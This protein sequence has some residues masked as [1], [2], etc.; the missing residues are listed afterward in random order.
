MPERFAPPAIE[1]ADLRWR[2]A[3]AARPTLDMR[4]RRISV[5]P[6][7]LLLV[8]GL[9]GAGK[10]TLL[11]AIAGLLGTI[12]PGE[13]EGELTVGG[14][15]LVAAGRANVA[16]ANGG[17][18]PRAHLE[19]LGFIAAGPA[20]TWALP[21]VVDDAAL[22]LES[23]RWESST[24]RAHIARIAA[25]IGLRGDRLDRA[26]ATLSGGERAQ[27]AAVAALVAAPSLLIADEPLLGIDD[28]AAASLRAAIF[29]APATRVV[30]THDLERELTHL[31]HGA[32]SVRVCE[33][34]AATEERTGDEGR[35]VG[36]RTVE[37][38][39]PSRGAT[40]GSG[41][42][43]VALTGA[44]AAHRGAP[45]VSLS[46]RRG[47]AV[48][49]TGAT[50]SGKSTLLG[51]AAGTLP[52]ALGVRRAVQALRV[53][54]V[55]QDPGLLLGTRPARAQLRG[56]EREHL[57]RIADALDVA[58]L[59]DAPPSRCS[60]GERRRLALA[61][62]LAAQPDLLVADE[63]TGGL[64]D[65]RAAAV[66]ALLEAAH[67]AGTTLL[68]ATH[69]PR[70]RLS[71]GRHI[72]LEE[73]H[74]DTRRSYAEDLLDPTRSRDP[75]S[76][77]P[78]RARRSANPLARGAVA[79]TWLL[80]S[81]MVDATIKDQGAIAL[82]ALLLSLMFGVRVTAVLRFGVALAAPVAG[83][84]IANLVGGA[85]TDAAL[86]AA[87]RLVALACGSLL[88]LRPFEALRLADAAIEQLRAPFAPT[89]AL[90][91]TAATIPS[92]L[93]EALERRAIRRLARAGAD[94]VLVVDSLD[95]I[96]RRA[97]GLAAAL[98]VRGVRLPTRTLPPTRFRPSR[99][100]RIDLALA[101][102]L[103][104]ALIAS[105]TIR[106]W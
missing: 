91:G 26:H 59:L 74:D 62:A 61:V 32:T 80:A 71:S 79:C 81:F 12:I 33:L 35:S 24:M 50:G 14:I 75:E 28:A 63:P 52:P 44:T 70:L 17:V 5:P 88:F 55:P 37:K 66:M 21:R 1:I 29:D 65:R 64:D 51:L 27:A 60:D 4:G 47:E 13:L 73:A 53:R 98:E 45:P 39:A 23:R 99:F 3:G 19:R 106:A 95:A 97:P 67:A 93:D 38:R 104:V 58:H 77:D 36:A 20:P 72:R 69:D 86:G 9:S 2:P 90:L 15:D 34:R 85:T 48:V 83:I 96:A 18:V 102:A 42:E 40:G 22:A 7:G 84:A 43:L 76:D 78:N 101:L 49:V 46:L 10:S 82:P 41:E 25:D 11:R 6:G 89:M 103:G 94:P 31:R 54:L 16:G 57:N 30:A 87:T 100:G 8:T 92:M 105:A 56:D 68:I